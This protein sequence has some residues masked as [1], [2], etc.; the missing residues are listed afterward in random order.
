MAAIAYYILQRAIIV[1]QGRDSLLATAIGR[2]WKGKFS[3]V[4]YLLAIPLELRFALRLEIELEEEAVLERQERLAPGLPGTARPRIS[5]RRS[6]VA[7]SSTR[8]P[9]GSVLGS[10][11]TTTP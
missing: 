5:A 2:D 9:S 8:S 7:S 6:A 11:S 1:Q 3:P 4:L 10:P